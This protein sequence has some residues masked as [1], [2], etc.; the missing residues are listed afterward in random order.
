[1]SFLILTTISLII[2]HFSGIIK[3]ETAANYPA[4][5]IIASVLLIYAVISGLLIAQNI[6]SGLNKLKFSLKNFFAE[7]NITD[8]LRENI[9]REDDFK[10]I[11]KEIA[12]LR[13]T[14][15]LYTDFA[16]NLLAGNYKTEIKI[17]SEKPLGSALEG[18]KENLLTAEKKETY[19]IREL[20][21][22]NWYQNGVTDFTLLLQQDYKNTQ[23]MSYPVIKKLAEH[24]GVEQAGIFILKKKKDKEILHLEAA[25]AYDKKKLLDTETEIGE[26]LVG[27]CAKQKKMIRIDDLPEGYTYIGSGLGED[28]PKSLLLMPL[29]YEKKLLGVLEIASLKKIPDYKINFLNVIAERIAA[30]IY[31]INTKKLTEKLAEDYKKQSEE[32]AEKEKQSEEKIS[33]LIKEKKEILKEKQNLKNQIAE[34]DDNIARILITPNGKIININKAAEK[35]YKIKQTDIIGKPLDI[36]TKNQTNFSEILQKILKNQT[37]SLKYSRNNKEEIT[38]KY[39]PVKSENEKIEKILL[40]SILTEIK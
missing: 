7:K 18:I 39:I 37:I 27:K 33:Q 14:Y 17:N 36:I 24:I 31:N 38:E 10:E 3:F 16:R 2:L 34:I 19:N 20:K 5:I 23:E 26:S 35:I 40:I 11:F 13:N 4:I 29:I 9:K 28:T 21:R 32:L 22:N 25:Y 1:M 15:K 30:E 6:S 8:N 12:D